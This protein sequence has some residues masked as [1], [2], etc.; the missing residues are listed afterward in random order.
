MLAY[1]EWI[2]QNVLA[3]APHRQYVF[4]LRKILRPMFSRSRGLLGELCHI[5]ERLL[6]NA[7]SAAKLDGRPGLILFVQTFGDLVT[8]NPHI[9]VL[10]AD[11]VFRVDAA[12]TGVPAIPS[13]LLEFGF[14]SEVLNLLLAEGAISEQL[15]ASFRGWRHTGFS[16]HNAVRVRG[17]DAEGRKKSAKTPCMVARGCSAMVEGTVHTSSLVVELL[18]V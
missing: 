9:H 18:S 7:Y 15:A 2:A 14:R 16:V 11:G 1:G 13:K 4:T 10:A 8:F 17:D 3:P 5:A 12:F 6:A